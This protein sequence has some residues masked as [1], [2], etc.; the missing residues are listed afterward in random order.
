MANI[1][2]LSFPLVFRSTNKGQVEEVPRE[3]IVFRFRL[4]KCLDFFPHLFRFRTR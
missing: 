1:L 3:S 4:G 2:F